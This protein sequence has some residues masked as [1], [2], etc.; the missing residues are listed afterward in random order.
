MAVIA[1]KGTSFDY[2]MGMGVFDGLS[3]AFSDAKRTTSTLHEALS[4]LKSKIDVAATVVSVDTSQTHAQQA[5]ARESTKKSSLTLAYEKLDALI[6]DTGRV[7]Q[8]ASSKISSRED[9]FYKR[10]YYLKPECKKTD[11]EKRDDWWAE[12]WQNFKDFWGGVGEAIGGFFKKVGEWCKEHLVAIITALAVVLIAVV[13]AI[14]LGPAAI[15][16]VCSAIAFF[17][18]AGDLIATAITGKDIYTLLKESGHPILAE[19]FAGLE[20]GATIAAVALSFVQLGTQIA[21]VGLK[22]F[23][24]GGQ[25]GFANI[26]KYHF[27]TFAN[28]IKADFKSVFG[29]G[30][31]AGDRLKAVWNIA[32]LNQSGDFSFKQSVLNY[33]SGDKV[34]TAVTNIGFDDNQNLIIKNDS[35]AQVLGGNV[36]DSVSTKKSSLLF[37]N[38]LDYNWT[39]YGAQKIGEVDIMGMY[40]EGKIPYKPDGSVDNAK[41]RKAIWKE[42]GIPSSGL[43]GGQTAHEL[44]EITGGK[45]SIFSVDSTIHSRSIF[46]HNGGVSHASEIIKSF[47]ANSFAR[48]EIMTVFR[49]TFSI[50]PLW[51]SVNSAN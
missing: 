15:I 33:R 18:A 51:Y 27:K 32:V 13:A 38:T 37:D 7:D 8:R 23:L 41:L 12:R 5:Q 46:S 42:A 31:K 43:S 44:Y 22:N 21:K 3:M 47:K 40:S 17:C 39:D 16:A 25:K 1:L 24:T 26:M 36:G 2:A 28:G 45:V 6:S 10:Y 19:M 4:T 30:L 34:I 11:K 9:D 20:W 14:F 49:Q 50:P 48:N 29:K 35:A